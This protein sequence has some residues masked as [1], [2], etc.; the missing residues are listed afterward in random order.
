[1][2]CFSMY[3]ITING[4][5]VCSRRK[6]NGRACE[7]CPPAGVARSFWP[8]LLFLKREYRVRA[9]WLLA[10]VVEWNVK[11]VFIAEM[12]EKTGSM[13]RLP[14]IVPVD[15]P[16]HI[17]QRGNNR[18]VCF[19]ADEDYSTYLGGV[20]NSS[21]KYK[22][23]VN[24]WVLITNHVYLLCTS[25]LTGRRLTGKKRGRPVGWRKKEE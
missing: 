11:L 12:V 20:A 18:Q 13:A 1:M 23:N 15:I 14:M 9:T 17:I 19:V 7:S 16:V 25:R 24:A 2:K 6:L 21:K 3:I 5:R 8:P 22:V 4:L 10:E